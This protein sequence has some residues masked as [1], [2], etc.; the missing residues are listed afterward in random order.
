LIHPGDHQELPLRMLFQPVAEGVYHKAC[1]SDSFRGLVAALLDDPGYEAANPASRLAERLRIA[2]DV[3]LLAQLQDRPILVGERD[4]VE[5]I[6]VN[7]DE[8]FI[9]SLDRLGIISV[10]PS[11]IG[12]EGAR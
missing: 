1:E 3:A 5:T 6:N 10:E 7:S 12:V 2:N 4:A 11:I 9:R 8:P